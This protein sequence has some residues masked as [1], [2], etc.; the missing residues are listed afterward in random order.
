MP[1]SFLLL[2]KKTPP[3]Y[4]T[5]HA[6]RNSG[7]GALPLAGEGPGRGRAARLSSH[8]LRPHLLCDTQGSLREKRGFRSLTLRGPPAVLAGF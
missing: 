1:K 8:T 4:P 3:P 7:P 6:P 2:S 5:P